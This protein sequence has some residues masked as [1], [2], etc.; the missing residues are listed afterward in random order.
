MFCPKEKLSIDNLELSRKEFLNLEE[1]S[2]SDLKKIWFS[3]KDVDYSIEYLT[4]KD[5]PYQ[6]ED[7]LYMKMVHRF[8]NCND[9]IAVFYHQIDPS[10][11]MLLRNRYCKSDGKSFHEMLEF[12]AWISNM[13]GEYEIKDM[14]EGNP[15]VSVNLWK[16]QPIK[17][18]YKLDESQKNDL[19]ERYNNEEIVAYNDLYLN[20]NT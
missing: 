20:E 1:I 14:I 2:V 5:L 6:W 7:P 18:F 4:Q 8:R 11:Q 9:R 17:F 10:N 19:I 15:D 13:I 3:Q 12:F 16:L